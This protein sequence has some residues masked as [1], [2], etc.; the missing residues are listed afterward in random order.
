MA[1]FSTLR[2]RASRA[3][4]VPEQVSE[5]AFRV[6]LQAELLKEETWNGWG[7]VVSS[8]EAIQELVIVAIQQSSAV[9]NWNLEHPECPIEVGQAIL[10]V[11]G[12]TQRNEMLQDGENH[13]GKA[14]LQMLIDV[15]LTPRQRSF[16]KAA[17]QRYDVVDE[18]LEAAKVAHDVCMV[19]PCPV[20]QDAVDGSSDVVRLSCGHH[21]HRHCAQRWFVSQRNFRCPSCN[22]LLGGWS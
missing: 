8:D 11:N 4:V 5:S 9:K 12:K 22:H 1:C 21:F 13:D 6:H 15:Q 3:Q 16:F 19:E 20:C 18:F 10:E 14:L 2:W 17:I 7:I